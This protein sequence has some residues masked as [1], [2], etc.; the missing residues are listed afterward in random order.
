MSQVNYKSHMSAFIPAAVFALLVC[1][2]LFLTAPGIAGAKADPGTGDEALIVL[3]NSTGSRWSQLS[4]LNVFAGADDGEQ[5]IIAPG[6]GGEYAFT[7]QNSARF[8]LKYTMKISDENE[9]GVPMEFRLKQGDSYIAGSDDK[10]ADISDLAEITDDLP[11]ES[12]AAYTLEWR[13]NGDNDEADTSVG[14]AA[15]DGAKYLLNFGITAEQSGDP[16][17][18]SDPSDPDDPADPGVSTNHGKPPQTGDTFNLPLCLSLAVSS[19]ILFVM[20]IPMKRRNTD[21]ETENA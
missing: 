9:A 18:P 6:S 13:W 12:E 19:G 5:R 21:E 17:D 4:R 3:E 14:I 11:H 10:W 20:F 2:T 8:P 1:L 16:I 7:V 15:Q